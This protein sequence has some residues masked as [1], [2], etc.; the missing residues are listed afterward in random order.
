ML[1]GDGPLHDSDSM[2]TSWMIL[3]VSYMSGSSR[4]SSKYSERGGLLGE[5]GG[6]GVP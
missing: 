3:G 2:C 5:R 6:G 4:T 1:D